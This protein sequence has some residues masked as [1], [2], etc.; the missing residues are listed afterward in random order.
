MRT[1]ASN[2]GRQRTLLRTQ[3]LMQSQDNRQ[4]ELLLSFFQKNRSGAHS[5][6]LESMEPRI[7]LSA[8]FGAI[9]VDDYLNGGDPALAGEFT[10]ALDSHF[11]TLFDALE[12]LESTLDLDTNLD[13]DLPAL[14]KRD[15]EL[16]SFEDPNGDGNY[17]N[18]HESVNLAGLM[19]FA[20]EISALDGFDL[21][22]D[23]VDV[24]LAEFDF[25][26]FNGDADLDVMDVVQSALY[27]EFSPLTGGANF[28]DIVSGLDG[29]STSF[30]DFTVTMNA[31]NLLVTPGTVNGDGEGDYDVT[32][33]F[34]FS[35]Y[36]THTFYF[37]LGRSADLL[38]ISYGTQGGEIF[39]A[40][41]IQDGGMPTVD[42]TTQY[43]FGTTI[44]VNLD[45]QLVDHDGDGADAD[46]TPEHLIVED[47]NTFLTGETTFST[48]VVADS[49]L[50]AFDLRIGFLDLTSEATST[51]ELSA[52]HVATLEDTDDGKITSAE[53]SGTEFSTDNDLTTHTNEGELDVELDITVDSI[54]VSSFDDAFAGLGAKIHLSGDPFADFMQAGDGGDPRTSPI[55]SLENFD[56]ITP[57]INMTG[58][59]FINI[60]EQLRSY[61]TALETDADLMGYD[62]PF[63]SETSLLDALD[64]TTSLDALINDLQYVTTKAGSEVELP[65]FA[66]V[67][68]LAELLDDSLAGT[69]ASL[70]PTYGADQIL[71]FSLAFTNTVV[72]DPTLDGADSDFDFNFNLGPIAD[73][74]ASGSF[75][76]SSELSLDFILGIDLS[77]PTEV[78]I[79]STQALFALYSNYNS[80]GSNLINSN[81]QLSGDAKF[82]LNVAGK[83]PIFVTVAASDTAGNTSIDDLRDD[84]Q[85]AIDAAYGGGDIQVL[86]DPDTGRLVI[87]VSATTVNISDED[88][89]YDIDGVLP[90][91]ITIQQLSDDAAGD[92]GFEELGFFDGQMATSSPLPGNGILSADASFTVVLDGVDT[93]IT[94]LKADTLDNTS[95]TELIS[96]IQEAVNAALGEGVASVQPTETSTGLGFRLVANPELASSLQIDA[97]NDVALKELGLRDALSG[98]LLSIAS[99]SEVMKDAGVYYDGQLS[100]DAHFTIEARNGAGVVSTYDV[101]VAADASNASLLDLVDDINAAI[102]TSDVVAGVENGRLVLIAVNAADVVSIRITNVDETDVA[103]TELGLETDMAASVRGDSVAFLQ[104][105]SFGATIG[106]AANGSASLNAGFLGLD[107]SLSGSMSAELEGS[108]VTSELSG[109]DVT[110][111]GDLL[112]STANLSD[113]VDLS[114]TG[115]ADLSFSGLSISGAGG[116]LSDM[117]SYLDTLT[118]TE[119]QI[120]IDDIFA[121]RDQGFSFQSQIDGSPLG[122]NLSDPT[123]IVNLLNFGE[124]QYFS[125]FNFG[126][127]LNVF[128]DAL[129]FLE[130]LVEI[131]FLGESLPFVGLN[132]AATLD[133]VGGLADVI[134]EMISS[135]AINIQEL[136]GVLNDAIAQVA[137]SIDLTYEVNSPGLLGF[138]IDFSRAADVFLPVNIDL[139][140]LGI[141]DIANL[142]GNANIGASFAADLGLS[143][144][145]DVSSI[146]SSNLVYIFPDET[147][148]SLSGGGFAEDVSFLASIGPLAAAIQGG[149]LDLDL[150]LDIALPGFADGYANKFDLTVGNVADLLS[151]ILAAPGDLFDLN[152]NFDAVLPVFAQLGGS[153]QFL[154]NLDFVATLTNLLDGLQFPE[155]SLPN[156]GLIDFSDIGLL[157]TIQIFVEGFDLVL[158]TI[159]DLFS[160]ELFGLDGISDIPFLGEALDAA[161]DFIE[162]IRSAVIQPLLELIDGTPA[163]LA[164]VFEQLQDL[165]FNAFN[166]LDFLPDAIANADDIIFEFFNESGDLI[167]TLT[168][169]F[170]GLGEAAGNT[171]AEA[172]ELAHGFELALDLGGEYSYNFG[173]VDLG[174]PVL[175]LGLDVDGGFDAAFA[176][177]LFM[178]LGVNLNDGFYFKLKEGGA[179]EISLDLSLSLP[180]SLTANLGFLAASVTNNNAGDYK[181]FFAHFAADLD[182]G[183]EDKLTFGDLPSAELSLD[184]AARADLDLDFDLGFSDDIDLGAGLGALGSLFPSLGAGI[185]LE[186]GF[187]NQDAFDHLA[188][189]ATALPENVLVIIDDITLNVGSFLSDVL[190]PVIDVIQTIVGPF[191]P[192]IDV[193]TA[194]IPVISDLAG[195]DISLLDI[196]AKFGY[197]NQGLVDALTFISD[198]Y[199]AIGGLTLSDSGLEVDIGSL[200][201]IDSL[202][203]GGDGGVDLTDA[204]VASQIQ[205]PTE[206]FLTVLGSLGSQFGELGTLLDGVGGIVSDVIGAADLGGMDSSHLTGNG[207]IFPFLE[208]PTQIIGLLF[209]RDMTLIT[210]DLA[211]LEFGFEYKQFFSIWGPI[212]VSLGGGI[213]FL[214]DFDFGYDT[215]GIRTFAENDFSNPLDLFEGFFIYDDSPALPGVD[216]PELVLS[217]EITAA[218]AINIGIAEAGVGGGI[219]A[220]ATADLNDP[221][222]DFKMRPSEIFSYIYD[223]TSGEITWDTIICIFDYTVEITAELFVYVEA[224]WGLFEKSWTFGSA[225]L[226]TLEYSCDPPGILA[227]DLGD[228]TLRLN[229]GEYASER[230]H[231]T[232]D[233]VDEQFTV[234]L[235]GN[236]V[237]VSAVIDG[238]SYGP[239]NYG[240]KDKYDHILG[241]A[242]LGND[243]IDLSGMTAGSYLTSDLTGGQGDDIIIGGAGKD[244]IY[245]DSGL[246]Q[247]LGGDNDDYIDG[248][249][250]ADKI[251]GGAGQDI[252]HGR[253]D[254]DIILGGS[255]ADIIF[256]EEGDDIISAGAGDDRVWG[257]VGI[258]WIAGGADDD[259]LQGELGDD[260]I[261]GDFDFD[262]DSDFVVAM[263]GMLPDL[264]NGSNTGNDW[265]SGGGGSDSISGDKG[266]DLI[267]GDSGFAVAV[268]G[269]TVLTAAGQ[270][271]LASAPFNTSG[272]DVISGGAG[273]D[274]IYGED[275]NDVIRGDLDDDLTNPDD[276]FEA[277]LGSATG[278]DILF[279]GRGADSIFGNGGNDEIYGGA[280]GDF[281][282]GND[283]ND[284][285]EGAAGRDV[286]FGDDGEVE[287]FEAGDAILPS[288]VYA[289]STFDPKRLA[290][291]NAATSSGNDIIDGGVDDDFIFGGDGLDTI[292]GDDGADLIFGDNGQALFEFHSSIGI[293]LFTFAAS[294][295]HAYGDDDIIYGD[296]GKD[297]IIGG[298]GNDQIF[299]DRDGDSQSDDIIAGD[300]VE[301]T[302]ELVVADLNATLAT[303]TATD[304]N[305]TYAGNDLIDAG[306][307]DDIIF[308]GPGDDQATGGDG[309]DVI[310]GDNGELAF[311]VASGIDGGDDDIYTLDFVRTTAFSL[312]GDDWL[313]G[314]AAED[315][316]IGGGGEDNLYGDDIFTLNLGGDPTDISGIS[317]DS[318]GADIL[319]GDQ[320][321]VILTLGLKRE[322]RSTDTDNL[323]GDNDNI[324]GNQHDDV[325]IGGVNGNPS[326]DYLYGNDGDDIILGDEGEV[327]YTA[328]YTDE[329]VRVRI[330]TTDFNL[331]HDD[332]IFGNGG[333][334]LVF[335]GTGADV[336][337]GD[338]D[339]TA[340]E[341]VE[342]APGHDVLFGDQGQVNYTNGLIDTIVGTDTAAIDGGDDHI[343]GDDGNDVIVGGVGADRLVGDSETLAG[344]SG[345]GEYDDVILGDVGT[346]YYNGPGTDDADPLTIDEVRTT[347]FALGDDDTILG[348]AG[349]DV[350]MGG[351]G[352]DTIIGD[353]LDTFT[354]DVPN[355]DYE[356]LQTNPG[357][358]ILLGD[359]GF[360]TW[361]NEERV[362]ISSADIQEA[363]GGSDYIQ[364][365]DGAD[366]IIGGVAGDRLI[367]E[368]ET[369]ALAGSTGSFDDIILG[370]E[371]RVLY[372]LDLSNNAVLDC[373]ET[374]VNGASADAS[375]VLGGDDIILAGAGADTALGGSGADTII[376]DNLSDNPGDLSEVYSVVQTNFGRDTLIGDQGKLDYETGLL[377][378]V[379]TTDTVDADGGVDFIAG[380]D[381]ADIILG[382]VAGD[383]LYGEAENT[384]RVE[385][386]AASYD[387]IILG[388]EGTLEYNGLDADYN[389]L[390]LIA[391]HSPALGGADTIFANRGNDRVFGGAAG[392]EIHGDVYYNG[393]TWQATDGNLVEGMQDWLVGDN[394][395]FSYTN[396]MPLVLT[397]TD[398]AVGGD[399]TIHGDNDNDAIIGGIGGDTLYGETQLDSLNLMPGEAGD[400]TLL[401][402]NARFDWALA[403]DSVEGRA[404]LGT[405]ALDPSQTTLDR[406]M[407]IAPTDGGNDVMFGN[408][409]DDLM[410]GGTGADLMWGDSGDGVTEAGD[411]GGGAGV[412]GADGKDL[413]FGDHGKVYPSIAATNPDFVNN[414]FFAIDTAFADDGGDDVMFGNGNDD[415]LQGQQGDDVIFGGTGDDDLIGGH[416]VLD[417][418][419]EQ[420]ALSAA[421]YDFADGQALSAWNPADYD[422][423]NDV[424]DASDG[425]DVVA[426]DNAIIIRQSGDAFTS[427]RFRFVGESGLMYTLNQVDVGAEIGATM[428]VDESFSANV[429][430]DSQDN[431]DHDAGRDIT[432]LNHSAEIEAAAVASPSTP[433]VFGNDVI[434]GGADDDELFGQLGDDIMQG[435]GYVELDTALGAYNPN[436]DQNPSYALGVQAVKTDLLATNLGFYLVE[437]AVNDGDDYMEG[438]GGNDRMYGGLGQDDMIGGSSNLFGLDG[439]AN[440]RP[441]G[442]DLMYGASGLPDRLE[443]NADSD[444][445]RLDADVMLGDNGNIYRLVDADGY[446][447]FNYDNYDSEGTP[448]L[449]PRAVDLLDYG[450]EVGY[451][452]ATG[453]FTL[454]VKADTVGQGDLM[455]GE[456]GDDI[457]RGMKGDDVL[458]GNAGDDDI[459]GEQ[460]NDWISGGTGIDGIL[461]DDGL[462]YTSRNTE[463]ANKTD[464]SLAEPLYGIAKLAET[465][466]EIATPGNLQRAT[467]H[468]DDELKLTADLIGFRT[469]TDAS[470]QQFNDIIF[471]G[472]GTDW[473]HAGDGDDAVSGAEALGYY[474]SAEGASDFSEVSDLLKLQQQAPS[475]GSDDVQD[476]PFWYSFA[477]YNP[478]DIL[479]FEGNGK[480]DEFAMYDEY[481][482]REQIWVDT[483]TGERVALAELDGASVV[484]FLLNFDASEG[485]L[486]TAFPDPDGLVI[487]H[488]DGDDRIFGDLGNDWIVGGTGR[489]NM[490]GGRGSDLINMDDDHSTNDGANDEPD[491]YQA[492]ADI[493]YAGAGRDVMILNT[494][495]DRSIDWVGEYNS[496]IV[497]FSPFGAFH[498]SRSLQPHLQDFLYDLSEADGADQTTPDG[499]LY[500]EH[501]DADVRTDDPD[502]L[503]NF[504]PFGEL[505]MVLQSDYDWNDQTGAPADPQ[506]GNLQGPREI[507]RRELFAG[508]YDKPG[509]G[510]ANNTLAF[511]SL[512]GSWTVESGSYDVSPTALGEEAISLFYLDEMQPNYMEI[513]ASMTLEKDKAGWKSNGY[514]IFDY[515]DEFNFKFAG[516]DAG[517]DKIQIGHRTVDGWV[518]D[519]QSNLQLRDGREYSLTLA[520]HGTVATIYVNG[521][522]ALSF[523][524]SDPI[525]DGYLGLATDGA[526][527]SFDDWQIQK[528][529]P[530]ITFEFLNEF[531]AGSDMLT[532]QGDWATSGGLLIGEAGAL[533]TTQ[534][535]VQ[536]FS[537]LELETLLQGGT[538]G[539]VFDYYSDTQYKFV[540]FDGDTGELVIGHVTDKGTYVDATANVSL[541]GN[542]DGEHTLTLTM[543]GGGVSVLVDDV[544]VVGH[545]YNS[546]LN[547]GQVGVLVTEDSVNFENFTVRGDD[548]AYLDS[549]ELLVANKPAT[550]PV[551]ADVILTE[552]QLLGI[553]HAGA[554]RWAQLLGVD[555]SELALSPDDFIITDLPGQTLGMALPD[556][557][558][559]IDATAAGYGWF[560]DET[561]DEDS[562]F[563]GG[564]VIDGMDLLTAVMH[565]MG[566]V[567]N[568]EGHS[569]DSGALMSETLAEGERHAE[570]SDDTQPHQD[571]SSDESLFDFVLDVSGAEPG[572]GASNMAQGL[573][574]WSATQSDS[575]RAASVKVSS[576]NARQ[577]Q[578]FPEFLFDLIHMDSAV[579]TLDGLSQLGNKRS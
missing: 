367:G 48:G 333:N 266:D 406:I 307:G 161:D 330:E 362:E 384:S 125:E 55:I 427:P 285:I 96:D 170:V 173:E 407:T 72:L 264:I 265:I 475:E 454:D 522:N 191:Q 306:G 177:S 493:V 453:Q 554:D 32:F 276:R 291:K 211:P 186:W 220:T 180:D 114:L 130:Q 251:D 116:V 543:L 400:D 229:M 310:V 428:L 218:L 76:G 176:W 396:G 105:A 432:L 162:D 152:F 569:S 444:G 340:A 403:E 351:T 260:L 171:L 365:N 80:A 426:G 124:L 296:L 219:F 195:E 60:L 479:R 205:N 235:D 421:D 410:M 477:P 573:I 99:D 183:L 545:V 192:L 226:L 35:L 287:I 214:A 154:G 184:F 374:D 464:T 292:G 345:L 357:D 87:T 289:S 40:D 258:D 16:G 348:G 227:T 534:I 316:I 221:N 281:L 179:E 558:I 483:T 257:G 372:T 516:I 556:G 368:A 199:D 50:A 355:G 419:D 223:T 519:T 318:A 480:P 361:A 478:G 309:A 247:L 385:G 27:A 107:A 435:D 118:D 204:S 262:I 52:E 196:A 10:V 469:S 320:G 11:D 452:L 525:N 495:A 242:G 508:E 57:F 472:L 538:G 369:L 325:L 409:G 15:L 120:G 465:D 178:G 139:G 156:F 282:F 91:Q 511:T 568:A 278:D 509:G 64:F 101:T 286:I 504:E 168:D 4:S 41:A 411:F 326:P 570:M 463:Q 578:N 300:H 254:D 446:L 12:D 414:D 455:F 347:K 181:D 353:N 160:G 94:V 572:Y 248:G 439:A 30:G 399:D 153:S 270:P 530:V 8:D 489:D 188:E 402:D 553:I 337:Q 232:T 293:S 438:N 44:G 364:G 159:G 305:E 134:Q 507:M 200:L 536:A 22:G 518:I 23:I 490:Y 106:L 86:V 202:V 354:G 131:D 389:T 261:W 541:K 517:T 462:L 434:A 395:S 225:D 194:P 468:A 140:E 121:L 405:F 29:F 520:M 295:D 461:G 303:L 551:G 109:R 501:K 216:T 324:F 373:V 470:V 77:T 537:R 338:N 74:N 430:A 424:L 500:V 222:D 566:H 394:G 547:D 274:T 383:T 449:R 18:D 443:R 98:A 555:P 165:I 128:D 502:P 231:G 356:T 127:V 328:D 363:D 343:Q 45:V 565:E 37:D 332:Y 331:G 388:D 533:A 224:L 349:S 93:L 155:I 378:S 447:S 75:A 31:D 275:G 208:D 375:A 404:E 268:D 5:Y 141:P 83:D 451:D 240:S 297:I 163:F 352:N 246:D 190:S 67:Q 193:L 68:E 25:Y 577:R 329:P 459:Y 321:E 313:S 514:I 53:L 425:N 79:T 169:A 544:A 314:G 277:G 494:G 148:I 39:G 440:L 360:A 228:G 13:I 61:L 58:D 413:L 88:S 110:R 69:L 417:G 294:T 3:R 198:L 217:G 574:D 119:I 342:V 346:V 59:S 63:L 241:H 499:G 488:N 481:L 456:D 145:V 209:G 158:G 157:D 315:I 550:D 283:G 564:D 552:E 431:P 445:H 487:L 56:L 26:D 335:G 527:T 149:S 579:D 341:P 311:N 213:N 327:I 43:A 448:E 549:A 137:G 531:D 442:A 1:R 506:P 238:V 562:E 418:I 71:S 250:G 6:Q 576:E 312:T 284:T 85:D 256:G 230:I 350:V 62:L 392:D 497:P 398:T 557:R 135:E 143:F 539:L 203:L 103:F 322:V 9:T 17:Y 422:D 559:L 336:V 126:D 358:D 498:I 290:T 73:I 466:Q 397:S 334:D 142:V 34:G 436:F 482:P 458:F 563:T 387:D 111:I 70:L 366:I 117:Q 147:G 474:Y 133:F 484:E 491:A 299:G 379:T 390:D 132:L 185:E 546:L 377:A 65:N 255:G 512:S 304:A 505:G 210:L 100:D 371:G 90:T 381:D 267:W 197:L 182:N 492:Y 2:F 42:I 115:D 249:A 532:L 486:E 323:D 212:G 485:D 36:K 24:N 571:S 14:L 7:L 339:A 97:V 370:D 21:V 104:D 259:I 151:D 84:V 415:I 243:S 382:G 542:K 457:M 38:G 81:G 529:P 54:G 280:N 245:G 252:I 450:Y 46:P 28:S 476:D 207:L 272:H 359:Q 460:G 95:T 473:I 253:L 503:R 33:N 174:L 441:D 429:T 467:I 234:Y 123:V 144:G 112:A 308:A 263:T 510:G 136:V 317:D 66:S 561:P 146:G 269:M 166:P 433:H 19:G 288:G 47:Q 113:L 575:N 108:F 82:R 548:P 376:G 319:I 496:Y 401:G 187:G 386:S 273:N 515:Q 49:T 535:D 244:V 423:L 236:N 92:A 523:N 301:L 237:M 138:D 380:N 540:T 408:G 391:T 412:D 172:L 189:F 164:D 298:A 102:P 528:L 233:D 206:G 201:G 471:G 167:G 271:V 279:G 521:G 513:L 526:K 437:D 215:L 51:Y 416:N 393:G 150:D 567:L 524:F 122:G 129:G 175:N 344:V 239:Q 89:S 78:A 20:A 560:V 420:D 302:R